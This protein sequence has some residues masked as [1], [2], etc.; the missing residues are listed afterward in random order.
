MRPGASI[1]PALVRF[2]QGLVLTQASPLI[3]MILP[4]QYILDPLFA[5]ENYLYKLV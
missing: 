2:F 5:N 4:R 1:W 3:A